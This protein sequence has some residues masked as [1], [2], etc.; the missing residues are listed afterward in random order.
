M[1][2]DFLTAV[3]VALITVSPLIIREIRIWRSKK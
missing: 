1:D 3:V 2:Q